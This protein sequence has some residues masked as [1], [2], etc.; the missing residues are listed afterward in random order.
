MPERRPRFSIANTN[1]AAPRREPIERDNETGPAS[2]R[3]MNMLSEL[4]QRLGQDEAER[5]KLW[6]EIDSTR[7]TLMT[8][9][10]KSDQAEKIFL[11]LENKISRSTNMK[12]LEKWRRLIEENQRALYAQIKKVESGNKALDDNQKKL[13]SRI[14]TVETTT[15]SAL[16]KIDE[17]AGTQD[18]LSRRIEH[19][20][21]DRVKLLK[22][23]EG[24]EETILHTQE[25]LRAK[26][27]VMLTDQ[28]TC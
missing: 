1:E 15:G 10:D 28:G 27:L 8:L 18:K 6:R 23:M 9:E 12:N 16:V 21:D 17:V 2:Q 7:Q 14:D 24:L 19:V 13:G 22:K 3:L 20:N 25:T 5:E 26:A 4:N 11:T